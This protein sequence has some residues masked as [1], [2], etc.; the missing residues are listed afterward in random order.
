MLTKAGIYSSYVKF[1]Y[2]S[3]EKYYKNPIDCLRNYKIK[4][5]RTFYYTLV[6]NETFFQ[7][8]VF[9]VSLERTVN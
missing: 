3:P 1:I 7:T 5:R 4:L 8:P 9:I 2:S 6:L